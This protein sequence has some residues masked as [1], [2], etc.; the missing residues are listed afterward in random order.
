MS[1]VFQN[2]LQRLFKKLLV[3]KMV[4]KSPIIECKD[5]QEKIIDADFLLKANLAPRQKFG[6]LSSLCEQFIS[7]NQGL[8]NSFDVSVEPVISKKDLKLRIKTGLITGAIPMLSPTSGRPDYGLVITP[9]FEWPG[10]GSMLSKM[11]WR[12]TPTLLNLPYLPGTE[13]KIPPWVLSTVVLSRLKIWLEHLDRKFEYKTDTL[14]FPKGTVNWQLYAQRYFS[15]AQALN[16][17]C[18]YPDL[19][20]N[21]QAKSLIHYVLRKQLNS[22]ESQRSFGGVVLDLIVLCNSLIQQVSTNAPIKPSYQNLQ[23]LTSGLTNTEIFQKG[24]E[25]IEWTV[26]ERGL[27]GLSDL[28]GLPWML[29]MDSFFEAWVETIGFHI[30]RNFGGN[31]KVGRKRETLSPIRWD[32]P[33]QGTQ[34]FLLP[35]V[36]IE[37]DDFTIIF[38]AKYKR[39]WEDITENEW[40]RVRNDLQEQH[41][42]DILQILAYSSL[43]SAK[44]VIACLVY[45]CRESTWGILRK[46]NLLHRHAEVGSQDRNIDIVL[47]AV[48]MNGLIKDQVDLLGSYLLNNL[49]LN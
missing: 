19:N 32:K 44:R 29:P 9:R 45:P 37:K 13:R 16:I 36:I 2:I 46:S 21:K 39:H 28:E 42:Q 30:T 26:D 48:P 47:T 25:A 1:L 4:A 31:I 3:Y 14:S 43:N 12:I 23:K 38:D 34:K 24:L 6:V 17:P 40:I 11:G 15:T 7:K 49:F 20:D 22:L 10:I 18:R 41:R 35:D 27:A 5:S 33:I 8:L